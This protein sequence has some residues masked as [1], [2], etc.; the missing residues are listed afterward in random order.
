MRI[1]SILIAVSLTFLS[2]SKN[3]NANE[4]ITCYF[5]DAWLSA[6]VQEL[7]NCVCETAILSGTYNSQNIYEIRI[8]DPLCNG[9]NTVHSED[10]TQL[11]HSGDR[12]IYDEY[13]ADVKNLKEV[14]RCSK[15]SKD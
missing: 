1:L 11:F 7:K 4:I 10:G 5:P 9:V 3:K 13:L 8:V 15:Q 2:C 12:A 6:K 14:W